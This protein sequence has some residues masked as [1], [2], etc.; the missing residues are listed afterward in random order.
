MLHRTAAA[1]TGKTSIL[2]VHGFTQTMASWDGVAGCLEKEGFEVVRIDLPGHGGSASVRLDFRETAL[3]IGEAGGRG[4]YVGYSMGGRLCLRLA[5]DRPDLVTALVLV[6]ASPGLADAG[7]R[8]AR[9]QSDARLA[10]DLVEAGTED[11][12]GRWLAQPLFE[13]TRPLDS[14]LAARRTNPPEGLSYAL[15]ELGTGSQ[16]PLWARLDELAVPVLLIVGE[17][18]A[19]FRGIADRMA[20]AIGSRA[21]IAIVEGA[22]HAVPLDQPELCA[23]LIADH[24]AHAAT[25]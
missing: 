25:S 18:D 17:Q 13:T 22:G 5:L 12:L 6:G 19:K 2:L 3:A 1:G 16:D 24:A 9:R 7:E 21:T 15:R 11:F 4:C 10:A 14:D 8:T 23:R 20:A